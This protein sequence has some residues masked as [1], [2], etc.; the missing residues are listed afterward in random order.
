MVGV[1][2]S[3][4]LFADPFGPAHALLVAVEGA[5]FVV[6]V[7]LLLAHYTPYECA[8]PC[9]DL[10][11]V[12]GFGGGRV[13]GDEGEE[14]LGAMFAG[15]LAP[16]WRHLNRFHSSREGIEALSSPLPFECSGKARNQF[17]GPGSTGV[18][19]SHSFSKLPPW[20]FVTCES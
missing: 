18:L 17:V 20:Y 3:G 4:D 14:G 6:L 9:D 19:T 10:A 16:T 1:P 15:M 13:W 2:R 11:G 7:V 12:Y 8:R 5:T